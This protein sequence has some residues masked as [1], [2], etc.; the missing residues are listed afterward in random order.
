VLSP[1]IGVSKLGRRRKLKFGMGEQNMALS[2]EAE[3]GGFTPGL[4]I[5]ATKTPT[6]PLGA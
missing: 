6:T 2:T 3:N 1:G 4:E 5:G